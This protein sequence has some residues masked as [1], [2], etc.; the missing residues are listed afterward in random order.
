MSTVLVSTKRQIVLPAELCRQLAIAP[1]AKVEVELSP[2][3]DELIVRPATT[4]KKPAS[5]L[6]ARV[7]HKGKPI[8]VEEMNGLVAARKRAQ[9]G[10][11]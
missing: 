9:A 3:G 2:A 4:R 7:K 6:F 5:I 1:G 11:L 8:T 10:K